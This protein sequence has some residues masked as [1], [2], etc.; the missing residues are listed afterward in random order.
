MK[1]A[2]DRDQWWWA[3]VLNGLYNKLHRWALVLTGLYNKLHRCAL[4][5]I[6]LYNKL[7]R[8][9]LVLTGLH[10]KHFKTVKG[11]NH[12]MHHEPVQSS[13]HSHYIYV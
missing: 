10:N 13:L 12:W 7:H 3:L 4:V 1:V 8:W 6:G 9:A 5:L 11:T 2:H